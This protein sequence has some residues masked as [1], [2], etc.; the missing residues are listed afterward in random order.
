MP[1]SY[2]YPRPMVTVDALVV[3][4]VQNLKLLL[5]Q[6]KNEPFKDCWA[7]PGGFVDMEENLE[8]AAKRELNEETGIV[9][10]NLIQYT[11]VGTP[12]RDPRG[13]TISIIYFGFLEQ[14][15]VLQAADDALNAEWFDLNK[16]P[17]LA[18]DHDKIVEK[19][20]TDLPRLLP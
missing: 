11:T 10:N 2:E 19:F 4:G 20:M 1:Y 6:R 16:L 5:I 9:I 15:A 18:F 12:G 7:L 13:R 14:E 17:E 3:A 8:D